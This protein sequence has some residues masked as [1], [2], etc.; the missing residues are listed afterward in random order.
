MSFI[1][2]KKFSVSVFNSI[3]QEIDTAQEAALLMNF[4]NGIFLGS[5]NFAGENIE[6]KS[7]ETSMDKGKPCKFEYEIVK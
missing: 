5:L 1:E 2:N 6:L 4:Y 3:V 7:I